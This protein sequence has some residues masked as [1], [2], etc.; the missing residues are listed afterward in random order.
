VTKNGIK[1]PTFKTVGE[2]VNFVFIMDEEKL[3][4]EVKKYEELYNTGG[5][6]TKIFFSFF[7][8]H[9]H[10]LIKPLRS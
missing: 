8:I 7:L 1:S 9:L 2:K 5:G 6:V 10:R 4:F 3:I